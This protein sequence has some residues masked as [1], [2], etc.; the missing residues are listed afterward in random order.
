MFKKYIVFFTAWLL[1]IASHA[2]IVKDPRVSMNVSTND[3]VSGLVLKTD[4]Q[5][6][7]W[8]AGGSVSSTNLSDYNNDVP[9]LTT[10]LDPVFTIW[11]NSMS[12]AV[13]VYIDIAQGSDITG[14]GSSIRPYKTLAY[15]CAQYQTLTATWD[16]YNTPMV[17]HVAGGSYEDDVVF[18]RRN[19]ITL[20]ADGW[21]YING[22]I[23]INKSAFDYHHT[24]GSGR[25]SP[26]T[27]FKG[28]GSTH[29]V[30]KGGLQL[31]GDIAFRALNATNG[32]DFYGGTWQVVY[33]G[34]AVHG[35]VE[36]F[37][38]TNVSYVMSP[39]VM[40]AGADVSDENKTYQILSTN[41][42]QVTAYNHGLIAGN[43]VTVGG[44][45]GVNVT[46]WPV[47]TVVD[48]HNFTVLLPYMIASGY[49]T[50]TPRTCSVSSPSGTLVKYVW[51]ASTNCILSLFAIDSKLTKRVYGNL[52]IVEIRD[53]RI[54]ILDYTASPTGTV[55]NCMIQGFTTPGPGAYVNGFKNC[56]FEGAAGTYKF[57]GYGAAGQPIAFDS[58]S[59]GRLKPRNPTFTNLNSGGYVFLDMAHGIG[60]TNR[61]GM[62]LSS[63][64]QDA[65]VD[66]YNRTTNPSS[67]GVTNHSA[68][69]QLDYASAGHTGFQPA[70][71]Y[72]TAEVDPTVPGEMAA[73]TNADGLLQSQ[74]NDLLT[75]GSNTIVINVS[76]VFGV[77]DITSDGS[78]TRPYKSIAYAMAQY[79]NAPTDWNDYYQSIVFKVASGT[80]TNDIVFPR[81]HSV[82]LLASGNV[83]I[84]GDISIPKYYQDFTNAVGS[85]L[86]APVT[87]LKGEGTH[88]YSTK[89]GLR[90][91]GDI[92]FS[93]NYLNGNEFAG[94]SWQINFH[95]LAVF[96]SIKFEGS[97][98]LFA[99]TVTFSDADI[100]DEG[101]VF[102][103]LNTNTVQA[104]YVNHGITN[105][106]LISVNSSTWYDTPSPTAATVIDKNTI[107]YYQTNTPALF[108]YRTWVG[109]IAV[110][111][112]NLWKY[113]YTPSPGSIL[114]LAKDCKLT[115]KMRGNIVLVEVHDCR[116][117]ALDY[118]TDPFGNSTNTY[119]RSIGAA[120]TGAYISGFK[121]CTFEGASYKF[122]ASTYSAGNYP[123]GF[124][125]VSWGR[126]RSKVTFTNLVGAGYVLL[127]KATG[128][129]FTNV[130]GSILTSSNVQDAIYELSTKISTNSI[131]SGT[132]WSKYK[133][134]QTVDMDNYG[135]TNISTNSIIFKDGT[136]LTPFYI[137]MWNNYT[138]VF[139]TTNA[140]GPLNMGTNTLTIGG[141]LEVGTGGVVKV[142]GELNVGT[143]GVVNVEEGGTLNI[144]PGAD[145]NVDGSIT[146]GG[147]T[148]TNW[149]DTDVTKWSQYP[150]TTNVD[151]N[152]KTLDN[153][154]G[155]TLGGVTRTNWPTGS[156][157][158]L[159]IV[160]NGNTSLLYH[161]TSSGHTNYIGAFYSDY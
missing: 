150:A 104:L 46:N 30:G 118:S 84:N 137:N 145:L 57:G 149:P 94:G 50:Y 152:D 86:F 153:I 33:N 105:G 113:V 16:E 154:K 13:E 129:A 87:L 72:L 146:F 124:D 24:A 26:V 61:T 44:S 75:R 60:F 74:I 68:L 133:A 41:R 120:D 70:G 83:D 67:G 134:L 53:S 55:T 25:Q 125:A 52:K 6:N 98:A 90:I 143:G 116:V 35:K 36:Y 76:Q 65:I 100:S 157:P 18:P 139:I 54:G 91:R 28:P 161:V 11:Y 77:D 29:Y 2:D 82:F 136:V 103:R 92:T 114:L 115:K 144:N 131:E 147:I 9:F 126:I 47:E 71:S 3:P 142:D 58:V 64:V 101:T 156:T 111:G 79:T 19:C 8:G 106:Q 81:K 40:Y 45:L 31:N 69:T 38:G 102:T 17:L 22:D 10:E 148:R 51:A 80:Y 73:R 99:P 127:D 109:R 151:I 62:A 34:V 135:L 117:G 14:T 138:N 1:A 15:A 48:R 122:G 159:Y 112:T 27:I 5:Y 89:Q 88:H 32:N 39:T 130:A 78:I 97:N 21:V 140:V 56:T 107:T 66:V 110:N 23:A 7:Y 37:G 4:G 155:M 158:Q 128:V 63:N 12:N 85:G 132:N 123:I 121:N 160:E 20:M 96:G 141:E 108:T 95:T 119:V 93:C 43:L 42:I 59:W 49:M